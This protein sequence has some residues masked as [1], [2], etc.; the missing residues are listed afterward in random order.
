MKGRMLINMENITCKNCENTFTGNYCNVCGQKVHFGKFTLKREIS[1]VFSNVFS[2]DK[3]IILTVKLLIVNPG[4]LI[5]DYLSGATK[6]YI[7][8]L[9]FLMLCVTVSVILEYIVGGFEAVNE[10]VNEMAGYSDEQLKMQQ[11]FMPVM[12]QY[13]DIIILLMLPFQSFFS[14]IFFKKHKYNYTEHLLL[15]SFFF[16]FFNLIGI[17]LTPAS[18]IINPIIIGAGSWIL[19]YTYC[20]KSFLKIKPLK[21]FLLSASI[22]ISSI[23]SFFI[24]SLILIILSKIILSFLGLNLKELVT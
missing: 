1:T 3:G 21:S 15:N 12:K 20:F 11:K 4:K 5:R 6:K 19:Y 14:Y 23:L 9:K 7:H 16:G 10:S 22:W 24:I 18:F 8:P 2:L 13:L 17:I